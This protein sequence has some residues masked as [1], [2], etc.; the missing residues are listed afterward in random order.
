MDGFNITF[1]PV[2]AFLQVRLSG[3]VY[4]GLRRVSKLSVSIHWGGNNDIRERRAGERK[5]GRAGGR[6]EGGKSSIPAGSLGTN[7]KTFRKLP[8]R[9]TFLLLTPR[10]DT[11]TLQH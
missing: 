4:I 11:Q 10:V 5:A 8:P 3:T 7:G 9:S 6:A 1:T 2:P